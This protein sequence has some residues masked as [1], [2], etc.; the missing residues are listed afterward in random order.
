MNS[1]T[2]NGEPEVMSQ[3]LSKYLKLG[4]ENEINAPLN[5]VWPADFPSLL[6]TEENNFLCLVVENTMWQ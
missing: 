6:Y 3:E 2:Q 5:K 1:L 4:R